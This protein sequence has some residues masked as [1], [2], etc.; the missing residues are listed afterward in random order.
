VRKKTREEK[1]ETNRLR[2]KR[3]YMRHREEWLFKER[4]LAVLGKSTAQKAAWNAYCVRANAI[5]AQKGDLV[6][7]PTD[8]DGTEL[9][10]PVAP[11]MP[12]RV[13]KE[14]LAP[15]HQVPEMA[16]AAE[17]RREFERLKAIHGVKLK[18]SGVSVEI[19]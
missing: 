10:A 15:A 7:V 9:V 13:E 17:R 14:D 11:V 4:K 5:E 2:Q 3:W 12:Q 8:A 6:Y 1:L 19:D 18:K 16:R